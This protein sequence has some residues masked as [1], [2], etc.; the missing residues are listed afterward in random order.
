MSNLAT[1]NRA[2][3]KQSKRGASKG[4]N[5]NN[6]ISHLLPGTGSSHNCKNLLLTD[7][8]KF[9]S[10]KSGNTSQHPNSKLVQ[11][12]PVAPLSST[13]MGRKKTSSKVKRDRQA[14][15]Q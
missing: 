7:E 3:Q 15:Q 11:Q 1:H 14:K 6:S 10:N 12:K 2:S 13:S 4:H 8:S 5:H 9:F